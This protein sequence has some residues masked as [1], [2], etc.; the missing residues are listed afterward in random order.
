[1]TA[2]RLNLTCMA[3]VLLLLTACAGPA[4]AD[5]VTPAAC[6]ETLTGQISTPTRLVNGP[7]DCDYWIPGDAG[8]PAR[9]VVSS[10]LQIEAGTVLMFGERTQLSIDGGSLQA[11][12]RADEPV[13]FTAAAAAPGYWDGIC[14]NGNRA[15]RLEHVEVRWGGHQPHPS[16][17]CRGAIAGFSAGAEVDIVNTTV[18]GSYSNGL[19]AHQ[20]Q[21]GEFSSNAFHSNREYGVNIE[22]AQVRK[23][24]V[25]SDYRGVHSPNGKP[26]V[27]AA[28]T[29]SEVGPL[30]ESLHV[31]Q[32]LNAPYRVADDEANYDQQIMVEDATALALE[33]GT[34]IYFAGDSQLLVRA[35][36]FLGSGGTAAEP[37]VLTS[38]GA[39]PGSWYGVSIHNSA[40]RLDGLVIEWAGREF[41]GSGSSLRFVST[42]DTLPKE[43][44]GVHITGSAGCALSIDDES[45]FDSLDVTFGPDIAEA[46]QYC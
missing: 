24:D 11:V 5:G 38:D 27:F 42:G 2:S 23:L 4:A 20:L 19:N 22:A 32:A 15:S 36:S 6:R 26:Y 1:M 40:A 25:N 39:Q 10:D 41:A 33:A 13:V 28:G 43:L 29:I 12:G 18:M 8:H 16:V 31:W 21:L 9:L 3:A 44:N 17:N 7:E 34:T 46:D 37:V 30:A 35:G 14:F 45:L